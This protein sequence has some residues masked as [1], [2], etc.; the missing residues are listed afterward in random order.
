MNV[1]IDSSVALRLVFNEDRQLTEWD[2][3]ETAVS[4][5]LLF[6][7]GHR[8]LDRVRLKPQTMR[9]MIGA[10]IDRFLTMVERIEFIE[11]DRKIISMAAQPLPFV[12][13]SLDAIHLATAREWRDRE[14][15]DLV[16]LTHD[17]G[18]ANAARR[19]G[20]SVLGSGGLTEG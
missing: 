5:I 14:K 3:V 13:K 2:R 12:I 8:A 11:L 17:G 4:S 19:V 16:F 18:L 20:F 7:E 1:Y 6:I 15:K 9:K 10:P